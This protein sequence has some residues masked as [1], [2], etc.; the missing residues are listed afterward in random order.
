[1]TPKQV[2]AHLLF[3]CLTFIPRE[4]RSRFC[5]YS[6]TIYAQC[7]DATVA[8]I[9]PAS[10]IGMIIRACGENPTEA[11][12]ISIVE[13]ANERDGTISHEEFL[14]IM[15][16]IRANEK[17]ITTTD[18]EEA[19]R[20]FDTSKSGTIHSSELRKVLT[21]LG[22]KLSEEEVKELLNLAEPDADGTINYVQLSKK[23]IP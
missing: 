13:K 6:S 14:A 19:F 7:C 1:M 18:L 3:R 10:R 11:R 12:I 23:L 5:S 8:G 9:V 16:D 22:E 20:V 4:K 21:T 2:G 17:R 15:Q